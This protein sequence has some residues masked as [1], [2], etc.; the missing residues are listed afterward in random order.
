MSLKFMIDSTVNRFILP[1]SIQ[2][3]SEVNSE[4]ELAA[5]YAISEMERA[6]GGGLVV[7]HPEEKLL[8]VSQVGYPLWLFPCAET[9]E[10]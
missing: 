4:I 7:K 9:A 3:N 5:V 6:K 1:F 8:F 2:K 10:G